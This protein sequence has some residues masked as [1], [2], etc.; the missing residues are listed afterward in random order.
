[1]QMQGARVA[2]LP[3]RSNGYH[4]P[5]GAQP[6]PS[7]FQPG[8][9]DFTGMPRITLD[10]VPTTPAEA[11]ISTVRGNALT[12]GQIAPVANPT[13]GRLHI[14]IADHDRL[15]VLSPQAARGGQNGALD[16]A[17][18]FARLGLHEAADAVVYS[19]AFS[20]ADVVEQNDTVWPDAAGADYVLW[21]QVQSARPN[22]AGPWVGSWQMRRAN[23]SANLAVTFDPGTPQGPTR[24][25]SFVNSAREVAVSLNSGSA[26]FAERQPGAA[27]KGGHPYSSGTGIVIDASGHVLTDNH[28]INGCADVRVAG[29]KVETPIAAKLLA[30]DAR[31]DLAV[32]QTSRSWPDHARFRDSTTLRPGEP[33]VITG[34]PLAG[35]VSK[36]MSVT[37]G[38]L[39]ALS[40]FQGN[41]NLL[42]FSAPAQPGNSGGPVLD[43]SGRVVGVIV[44]QLNGLAVALAIGGM[45]PQNV[46]FATKANVARDYLAPLG[47]A[48]DE[49]SSPFGEDAA[50]VAEAARNF[51]VKVECWK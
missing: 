42:Q 44:S 38:S 36:E 17:A 18:E 51:T 41:L 32:L 23:G 43:G 22:N 39:N 15:R 16:W 46:N 5:P 13:P 2:T 49:E 37:T 4:P 48:L 40:G 31:T 29:A 9:Y 28:V 35:L 19:R 30:N 34:F 1:M 3:L 45:V 26:A 6:A 50:T 10:G 47:L 8:D 25:M 11:L 21:Y 33:L 12:V 27:R 14:V 20:S 24:L 7:S